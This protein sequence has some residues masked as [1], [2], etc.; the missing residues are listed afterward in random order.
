MNTTIDH[1]DLPE[2]FSPETVDDEIAHYL[3]TSPQPVD[4]AGDAHLIRELAAYHA[5]PPEAGAALARTRTRLRTVTQSLGSA[6]DSRRHGATTLHTR[7]EWNGGPQMSQ[8]QTDQPQRSAPAPRRPQHLTSLATPL[9][10]VAAVLVVALLVGGFVAVLHLRGGRQTAAAPTWQNVAITQEKMQGYWRDFDPTQ[11]P[12]Q[13]AVSD[14]DGTIYALGD[15]HLWYSVNGGATYQ[16]FALPLP[17]FPDN[18]PYTISTV[19]GLR[20]VFLSGTT[21]AKRFM[22][23]CYA[24]P[25]DKSWR[26]LS[27][28]NLVQPLTQSGSRLTFD[29]TNIG[30]AI[31]SEH[32]YGASVQARAVGNWLFLLAKRTDSSEPMLIGTPD[33]GANWYALSGTLP[34]TCASF[35]VNPADARQLFCLMS[36][37]TVEQT[38]DGG[39]TWNQMVSASGDTMSVNGHTNG[40]YQSIW[41]SRQA[42]YGYTWITT[43]QATLSRHPIGAGDWS[44]VATLPMLPDGGSGEVIGVSPD[45]TVYE[46]VAPRERQTS[47][48]ISMLAPG[49][50][51][52]T[53]IGNDATLTFNAST[54][55]FDLGGLFSGTTP[56]VY[57]HAET[58][59]DNVAAVPRSLYRLALPITHNSPQPTAPPFVTPTVLPTFTPTLHAACT[60]TRGDMANIQS[61]G[62]GADLGTFP[63]RWGPSEGVAL[64]SLYFGRWPDGTLKVQVG[65]GDHPTNNR[66]DDMTYNREHNVIDNSLEVTLAQGE[67]IAASILPKDVVQ[68][69]RTQQGNDITVTYCSAALIAAFPASVQSIN[70][71]MPHNGLVVATYTLRENGYLFSIGF[72]LLP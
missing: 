52:F 53:P 56:A 14:V 34:G 36:D 46:V 58:T 50:R 68:V 30:Q 19:P 38:A 7:T 60:N 24:E 29:A 20:G 57:A 8:P 62:F 17:P 49:A 31:F 28:S 5:L 11:V 13:Y 40:L 39:L 2:S 18:Q 22:I 10:A 48:Q 32:G 6:N 63:Q 21:G 4:A 42:V 71:P 35:A 25:G 51:Q 65:I 66:V 54:I 61:G 37:H 23:I 26:Y 70:G 67:A 47:V 59:E 64:G 41:A 72:G 44:V 55:S 15:T 45:D 69:R 1:G 43:G 3:S 27:I 12:V 9:R 16:P 33:F